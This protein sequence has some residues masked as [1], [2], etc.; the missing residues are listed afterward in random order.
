MFINTLTL[1]PT[2]DDGRVNISIGFIHVSHDDRESIKSFAQAWEDGVPA[3]NFHWK[4]DPK[5]CD[6]RIQLWDSEDG[7][8]ATGTTAKDL[9]RHEAT[10]K[11]PKDSD[12]LDFQRTTL[13][14]FGHM[15]GALHEQLNPKFPYTWDKKAVIHSIKADLRMGTDD[16]GNEW[17]ENEL[18]QR[19]RDDAKSTWWRAPDLEEDEELNS[20][21]DPDSIMVYSIPGEFLKGHHHDIDQAYELSHLDTSYMR[22]A[23]PDPVSQQGGYPEEQASTNQAYCYFP[24]Q[25]TNQGYGYDPVTG[26]SYRTTNGGANI[27]TDDYNSIV[28]SRGYPG[29]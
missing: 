21:F 11:L 15:L 2:D 14:E 8:S 4:S 16:N 17:D 28:R 9:S 13:H 26:Q 7:W 3:L 24:S 5:H 29:T 20:K 18:D 19:A 25:N 27:N 22:R 10:M 1:W 12:P 6:V 23:Y